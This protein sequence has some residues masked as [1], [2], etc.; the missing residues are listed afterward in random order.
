MCFFLAKEPNVSVYCH[1][2]SVVG[3]VLDSLKGGYN[4]KW[5]PDQGA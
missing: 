2:L 3:F 1:C 4:W 5:N